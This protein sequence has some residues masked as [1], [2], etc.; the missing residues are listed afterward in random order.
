L[1][2]SQSFAI[3]VSKGQMRGLLNED[4][5]QTAVR[6]L[7]EQ[8]L[9]KL[10]DVDWIATLELAAS[11][12]LV[13]P[14]ESIEQHLRALADAY[15]LFAFLR[16]TPDVQAAVEKMFSHGEIWL[17][18]AIILPLLAEQLGDEQ[19]GRFTRMIEA[20]QEAGMDLF[21]SGSILE[22]LE[23][24]MNRAL[25]CARKGHGWQGPV[26]F[27]LS[28]YLE[29]GRSVKQLPSWL[30]NF[31]GVERPIDD[32]ADYLEEEFGIKRRDLDAAA[33]AA[34][35]K[36][37]HALEAVWYAIH[38]KRRGGRREN[39]DDNAL[40]RLVS[41]DVESYSGI[42]QLRSQQ[43]ASPFGYSAWWLTLDQT[44]IG[45]EP[46]LRTAL[47]EEPPHSPVLS[48]DFLVN[49][50]AFGPVR[51]HL[52]KATESSLPVVMQP[53]MVRYLTPEF[54]AEAEKVREGVQ[55]LPERVIRRHVRDYLDTAKRRVGRA[56]R[57]GIRDLDSDI[58]VDEERS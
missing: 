32:I 3:A 54:L 43:K 24:H 33:R 44:A 17:D 55:E 6:V 50:L 18:A 53:S 45:L 34:P 36:L 58:V 14:A 26:P 52:G 16:E 42:I 19:T 15:T 56:T 57:A 51:R 10:K 28:R 31:R 4:L 11:E 21:V 8:P 7:G 9:P 46:E 41:H 49:Y 5:R 25:A 38:E 22:E 47:G 30:D 35:E 27:L 23:R 39:I 12:I 20:A 37:R 29:S 48:A 40:T 1:E 2:R 13:S